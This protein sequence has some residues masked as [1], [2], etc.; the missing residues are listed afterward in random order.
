MMTQYLST[1]EILCSSLVALSLVSGCSNDNFVAVEERHFGVQGKVTDS[2]GNP[3]EGVGIYCLFYQF[4]VPE[5]DREEENAFQLLDEGTLFDFKLYQNFPNPFPN[6]TYIRFSLPQDCQIELTIRSKHSNTIL[7]TERETLLPG[8]YQ[9]YLEDI[10]MNQQLPNAVY[11]Y[12]LTAD[13]RDGMR[14]Y[15][16][17]EMLVISDTGKPNSGSS[18][19]GL[20]LFK[21]EDAFV[22]DSV[23]VSYSSDETH[24]YSVALGNFVNLLIRKEGYQDRI[25][26]VELYPTLLLN[27]DIVLLKGN[28][29]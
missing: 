7:Y 5:L 2:L 20:Y 1:K 29:P 28:G 27:R 23:R 11:R 9:R 22:G 18:A 25:T 19:G 8:L 10:V 4:Y 16:E 17:K 12:S 15:D 21:Y 14:Y 24:I 13:G 6:S 3:I 26:G